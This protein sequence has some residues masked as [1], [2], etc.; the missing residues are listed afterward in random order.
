MIFVRLGE[1]EE[2]DRQ[3]VLKKLDERFPATQLPGGNDPHVQL[4]LNDLNRELANVLVYLK[5][6][7]SRRGSPPSSPLR[8]SRSRRTTANCSAATRAMEE[9]CWLCRRIT[10]M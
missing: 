8:R 3:M 7:G 1:P 5:A 2:A 10:P 9:R 6:R 4:E